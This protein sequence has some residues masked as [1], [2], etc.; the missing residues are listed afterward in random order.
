MSLEGKLEIGFRLVE[1]LL[2]ADPFC[3]SMLVVMAV[4][5]EA[6]AEGTEG[7]AVLIIA[8]LEAGQGQ[9]VA[10]GMAEADGAQGV[11]VG[12]DVGEDDLM[13]FP[14]IGEDFTDGESG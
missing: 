13:T 9:I 5:G 4:A 11:Q 12:V 2:S 7:D 14:G 1:T 6:V 10:V 8:A 3:G